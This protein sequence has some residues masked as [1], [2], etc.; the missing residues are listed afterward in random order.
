MLDLSKTKNVLIVRLGKIGDMILAS[1]AI[2]IIKNNYPLIKI[3]LL[4]LNKNK[5]L[6]KY[7]PKISYKYFTNKNILL[8]FKLFFLRLNK[9]DLLIDLNDEQSKTSKFIREILNPKKSVAFHFNIYDK[10]DISIERPSKETTHIIERIAYLLNNIGIEFDK[11]DILP[12]IY[13]GEIELNNVKD[14]ITGFKKDKK[15]L[16]VN[17]SAGAPIRYWPNK[18]W[19]ELI[20]LINKDHS[21]WKVILLSDKKDTHLKEEITKGLDQDILIP[22][23]FNS[24]QH[25]ASYLSQAD[26]VISPDTSAVHIASAF[27]IPII[28]LY[29]NYQ[30]NFVSWQPLSEKFIS[31]K[32]EEENIDAIKVE[33]VFSAFNKITE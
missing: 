9:Y 23:I 13:L 15:I 26:L 30:W 4:T 29:P 22:Q 12:K 19:F 28:A 33:E 5:E 21:N 17:L 20:K 24:F 6:L 1:S 18:K 11:K 25:F 3:S 27:N 7:N 10:E 31:I 14:Q 32:S 8:Y 16:A 2:E